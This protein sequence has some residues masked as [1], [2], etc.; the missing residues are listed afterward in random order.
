[1]AKS[2]TTIPATLSRFTAA[3]INST[4]KRRVAAYARVS[5]DNEEQLTSYEA[6]VDYYTN[7]I[8]GRDDWEFAGVYTDEGIT[9]TNTK[10]REGFKSMVADALA[11][12]IDLIITKSV[13]RFAR[14]TV[15]SLTTIRSL[16]EHNVECYFEKENI[17]TFDG[18]GELLLTIMSSLAQEESRSISE[19]CTWGQRKRFA[20]GKVTVPFKRFLG[21]DMG[22]DH[23]LVVNPEQAKL[24]KRIYGMFLQGQSPFQIARTLTEEGIPSPGGKDHWNPSNIKSILTNEKYK[25]DALLQKSFTVDFLTKKKKANEGEIPQYYVKDNHEA[26]IDPETFEMVQTLMTTRTKGRNRKSSVSIFSSKVKCGD[27]G[28]WYGPKV[29]H[30]NDAYRKV[31]WQCNHKFDG[32]KCTTPTLNEEQ[33]KAL[34]LKAANTVIGAKEQFIAIFE[35]TLAPALATD[36]LERELADLEAEINIAAELVE[37]CIRENAHVALDQAEYQKRYDGLASRYDKAKDRHDEVTELIAERISRRKRIELYFRELRKREPLETFRD[38]DWLSMVDHMTVYS[39]NDIRV[40]FKDG[41][42]IKA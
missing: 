10:K 6:Q 13:S 26:I 7:Y 24:V 38:E 19:N 34:F 25:G 18:K 27:C 17:W 37:E 39:K 11:G 22:P 9:G 15:D 2:V 31:I 29:W 42:E 12:K 40:T 41:T 1:M 32:Q 36:E 3:P 30:S 20:D 14:N 33:I 5:T 4:K 8:Q 23:N 16:K 28:S 35:R 21:Y